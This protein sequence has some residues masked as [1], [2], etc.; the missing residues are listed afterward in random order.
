MRLKVVFFYNNLLPTP[1]YF[2]VFR[3]IVY[4][5]PENTE[6]IN[7]LYFAGRLTEAI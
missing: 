3:K 6:N 2:Y 4:K 7:L 5:F 1:N